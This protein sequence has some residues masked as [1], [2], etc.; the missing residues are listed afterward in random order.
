MENIF[1]E[2][3]ITKYL[4]TNYILDNMDKKKPLHPIQIQILKALYNQKMTI[5]Y[6]SKNLKLPSPLV[7]YHVMCLVN[8][9]LLKKEKRMDNS[10]VY[11]VN[12]EVIKLNKK[13]DKVVILIELT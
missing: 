12:K 1:L 10:F 8:K 6:L 3:K 5:Y 13:D 7:R 9:N 11:F 4:F 2:R